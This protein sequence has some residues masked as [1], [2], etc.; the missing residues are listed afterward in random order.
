MSA[1]ILPH[2]FGVSVLPLLNALL[3]ALLTVTVV[4]VL[5]ASVL[6]KL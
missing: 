5:A 1:A 6:V 3:L 4:A 2:L